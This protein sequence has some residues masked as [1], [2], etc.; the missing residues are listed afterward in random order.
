M[1]KCVLNVI[2]MRVSALGGELTK[3]GSMLSEGSPAAGTSWPLGCSLDRMQPQA[4]GW[5]P[6]LPRWSALSLS[7]ASAPCWR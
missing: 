6:T 5:T 3:A 2:M 4:P 7:E 1:A